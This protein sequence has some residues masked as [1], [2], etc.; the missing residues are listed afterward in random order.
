ME[1][2]QAFEEMAAT[3]LEGISLSD[4]MGKIARLTQA[5]LPGADEVSVTLIERG[6]PTTVAFTGPLAVALDERQYA[7]GRGPCLDSIDAGQPVRVASTA[8]E[9][10]W[11]DWAKQAAEEGCGSSLSVPVPLQREV[12]AA[13]NVYSTRPDAFDDAS[14][15]LG[16]T[17]AAYAGVTLANKHLYDA[18]GRIVEQL[19][20]AMR[21]RAVIEQAKGIL[22]AERRCTAQEAFDVLVHM[23][24]EQNRKLREVAQ[25][26]VDETGGWTARPVSG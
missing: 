25:T 26:L 3:P 22:M 8:D 18:Q 7:L 1:P 13:L 16:I 12:L 6:Q 5:V 11:R 9:E 4:M 24:Q 17:F 15:E 23:S 14:A 2:Q 21:S 20:N 19:Q 10:R